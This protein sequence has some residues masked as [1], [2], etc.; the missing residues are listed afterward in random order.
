[1]HPRALA[2][3]QQFIPGRSV[4]LVPHSLLHLRLQDQQ[5]L[6]LHL[7]YSVLLPLA[8]MLLLL[9][10]GRIICLLLLL[11]AGDAAAP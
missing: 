1:M 6:K 9:L 10:W 3:E 4:A 8:L 2:Y 5:L 11:Q 7:L